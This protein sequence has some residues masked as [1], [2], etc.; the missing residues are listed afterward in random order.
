[1][2]AGHI[3]AEADAP[4][5]DACDLAAAAHYR[6]PMK[7]WNDSAGRGFS[8][9][10]AQPD[11]HMEHQFNQACLESNGPESVHLNRLLFAMPRL[12]LYQASRFPADFVITNIGG[13][14]FFHFRTK[15]GCPSPILCRSTAP[16]TPAAD[17]PVYRA[18]CFRSCPQCREPWQGY[19]W[20]SC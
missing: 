6:L 14:L 19:G 12:R 18:Q 4:V 9:H 17:R 1:M 11:V 10:A 13:I 5:T 2:E 16:E 3:A 7:C 15:Q 8:V 20:P